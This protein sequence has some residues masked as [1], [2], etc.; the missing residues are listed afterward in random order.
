M[1]SPFISNQ[2]ALVS[3]FDQRNLT[4][5]FVEQLVPIMNP[6][7][8]RPAL[9]KLIDVLDGAVLKKATNRKFNINRQPNDFPAATISVRGSLVGAL[10]PLTLSDNT[11]SS[12]P[13]GNAVYSTSGCLAEVVA[14]TDGAMTLRCVYSPTGTGTTAFAAADFAAGQLVSDRG[15]LGNINNRLT[16]ETVF[17]LPNEYSNY[18]AQY[19]AGAYISHEDVNNKTYIKNQYGSDFYALQKESQALQRMMQTYY[20]RLYSNVAAVADANKPV[21]ASLINQINTMGGFSRGISGQ[22]TE[23]TLKSVIRDYVTNGGFTGDEIVVLCG[24]QYLGDIQESLG[25]YVYTA[26]KNNVLGGQEVEGLNIYT[27][28]FEGLKLKFIKDPFL[29]NKQIFGVDQ[30]SGY[31]N[32][33]RSAIF[34]NTDACKTEQGMSV[35]FVCDYYFGNT[36]D[37]Q[38]WEVAGSMDSKG[39]PVTN[40]ATDKKGCQ[41]NF[42]L[43]KQTQLM[44]PAACMYHGN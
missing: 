11:F 36:A 21:G 14:K 24:S 33:S 25:Q 10:L 27:Y 39:N 26:G 6:Q 29:D 35:P 28:G 18:I 38:R 19:D 12:I 20:A 23:T 22:V 9:S 13:V 16:P 34:M 17:T 41:I 5:R 42:T 2:E 31:S 15:A 30:T 4:P 32:R 1:S 7:F 3:I 37:V 43:D 8:A 44:N 40:G